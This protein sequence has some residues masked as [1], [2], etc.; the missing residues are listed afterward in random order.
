MQSKSCFS[1]CTGSLSEVTHEV[2]RP[3]GAKGLCGTARR[4]GLLFAS[5]G[6]RGGPEFSGVA[7]CRLVTAGQ[8]R[9]D[10]LPMAIPKAAAAACNSAAAC[11]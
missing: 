4:W 1:R 9:D 2:S 8:A 3:L 6:I 7:V 5:E 11:G 10:S